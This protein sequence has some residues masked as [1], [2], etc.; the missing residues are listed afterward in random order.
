MPPETFDTPERLRCA[1][2]RK[3]YS[4][5]ALP[6]NMRT[7]TDALRDT[8]RGDSPSRETA[9]VRRAPPSVPGNRKAIRVRAARARTVPPR[10]HCF[11]V[12]PIDNDLS[13]LLHNTG[14]SGPPS[15]FYSHFQPQ[16]ASQRN[17]TEIA[18]SIPISRPRAPTFSRTRCHTRTLSERAV[19]KIEQTHQPKTKNNADDFVIAAT[20]PARCSRVALRVRHHE[21]VR[22]TRCLHLV[23]QADASQRVSR[24]HLPFSDSRWRAR[25]AVFASRNCTPNI[26][27]DVNASMQYDAREAESATEP[28]ADPQDHV[29]LA[30]AAVSKSV[31]ACSP[32]RY[33]DR[34]HFTEHRVFPVKF[35]RGP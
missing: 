28:R 14:F 24:N 19:K 9:A 16:N 31:R 2:R 23:G 4:S 6:C 12:H 34:T 5:R 35:L 27:S 7:K 30:P 18:S 11:R 15:R 25:A 22:T 32:S 20:N 1:A 26:G 33:P 3:T 21:I 13:L 8:R 17:R 10:A 29:G